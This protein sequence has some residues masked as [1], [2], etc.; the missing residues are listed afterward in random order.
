MLLSDRINGCGFGA[1][2]SLTF[3]Q[4][5][6]H[7]SVCPKHMC[8]LL[9]IHP[10]ADEHVCKNISEP[11]LARCCW[12]CIFLSFVETRK[13]ID[14]LYFD[15]KWFGF[16][17]MCGGRE[18]LSRNWFNFPQKKF[19]IFSNDYKWKFNVTKYWL[20]WQVF[21]QF[22]IRFSSMGSTHWVRG[23]YMLYVHVLYS[24][25]YN[26]EFQY[27]T[28]CGVRCTKIRKRCILA[29]WNEIHWQLAFANRNMN[30]HKKSLHVTQSQKYRQLCN[31][32]WM[33]P[34][35]F[36]WA[37]VHSAY[38]TLKPDMWNQAHETR[39]VHSA[40]LNIHRYMCSSVC[41]YVRLCTVDS[42]A[43]Q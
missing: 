14:F 1:H 29:G 15:I 12:F 11:C 6:Q 36:D 16:Y 23:T 39:F 34:F 30:L 13:T 40:H 3:F 4:R 25:Q 42:Y 37:L 8:V 21:F 32:I 9:S 22:Q 33:I 38:F 2:I 10:F 18:N 26:M 28:T 27:I 35:H 31:I 7:K 17:K 41:L 20:N 43:V 19:Q 24:A 5:Q